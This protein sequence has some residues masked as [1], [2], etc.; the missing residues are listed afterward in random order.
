MR[1]IGIFPDPVRLYTRVRRAEVA[2][3]EAANAR[4]YL[5][6]AKGASAIDPVWTA[7]A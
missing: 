1:A 2:A 6:A 4:P 7:A 5:I 3:W